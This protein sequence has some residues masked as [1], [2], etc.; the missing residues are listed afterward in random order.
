MSVCRF[1][2]QLQLFIKNCIGF[3]INPTD[4]F[5]IDFSTQTDRRKDRRVLHIPCI[6][7]SSTLPYMTPQWT[8]V[9]R[10]L[11]QRRLVSIVSIVQPVSIIVQVSV[12]WFGYPTVWHTGFLKR[13]HFHTVWCHV[14]YFLVE[15]PYVKTHYERSNSPVVFAGAWRSGQ[16]TYIC[17]NKSRSY[18]GGGRRIWIRRRWG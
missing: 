2:L 6:F 4:G 13:Q 9:W 12:A 11:C 15:L 5:V 7:T 10:Q 3:H 17:F 18:L 1:S 8:A 14:L 16:K